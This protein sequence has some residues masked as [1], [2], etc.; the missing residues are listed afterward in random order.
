MADIEEVKD[1]FLKAVENVKDE[2]TSEDAQKVREHTGEIHKIIEAVLDVFGD[3]L[4][5]GDVTRIGEIVGPVMKLAA[6]FQD[7]EGLEKKR[8]VIEVVWLVYRTVDTYPDGNRNNINI[9]FV[10]GGIERKLERGLVAF[11]AGMAVDAL[12]KRM[13]ASEEV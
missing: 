4:Q 5:L 12:Y 6:S 10:M 3:G 2:M 11:A 13:K 7:Y 9:P 8:F 1:L